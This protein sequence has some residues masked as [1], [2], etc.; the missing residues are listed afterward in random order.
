[1]KAATKAWSFL[2]LLSLTLVVLGHYYGGREGLL[3]ALILTL[4]I[5]SYVYF[6]EDH[7]ILAGLNGRRLEG[8]DSY[9]LRESLYRL[10]IQMRV[11]MPRLLILPSLS[12][13]AAVVGR[14]MD[15]GTIILTEG[16]LKRFSHTEIEAVLAY[17]LAC[18][19]SLN[20]LAYTVGSFLASTCLLVTEAL[21]M[22]LRIPILEKKNEKVIISQIFTRFFTPFIGVIL[23]LAIRPSLYRTADIL[24]AQTLNDPKM[25]AQVLWKL[26]AYSQNLPFKAP[27]SMAHMYMVSP[28]TTLQWTNPLVAHPKTADRIKHLVGH[29]PI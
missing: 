18:I 24:A 9:G 2:F 7:R 20:T 21:D 22:A 5:N 15:R 10:S 14:G 4:G 27:L 17:Q 8:Q 16:C 6:F 1:M 26:E 12:P 13:Q 29:Y 19:Q 11:P 28:L 3:T 25:L 23:R